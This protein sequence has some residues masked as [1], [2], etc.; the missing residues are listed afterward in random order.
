MNLGAVNENMLFW[1]L[2]VLLFFAWWK[3]SLRSAIVQGAWEGILEDY[4]NPGLTLGVEGISPFLAGDTNNYHSYQHFIEDIKYSL[5]Q[6]RYNNLAAKIQICL[7]IEFSA[8]VLLA[9]MIALVTS[10]IFAIISE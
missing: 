7:T 10:F 4:G 9:Y 8:L 3:S 6:G 2:L 5:Y 1:V